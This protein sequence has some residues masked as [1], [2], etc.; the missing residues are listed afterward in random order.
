MRDIPLSDHRPLLFNIPSSST[1]NCTSP[2][3][4]VSLL[5]LA[6]PWCV[7]CNV[8]GGWSFSHLWLLHFIYWC[9][10][11]ETSF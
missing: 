10:W 1:H 4:L 3:T 6:F 8:F 2:R 5:N 11:A 7:F 9:W